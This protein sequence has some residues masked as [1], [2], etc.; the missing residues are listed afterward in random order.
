M[1]GKRRQEVKEDNVCK[2]SFRH[3]AA[4]AELVNSHDLL[5]EQPIIWDFFLFQACFEYSHVLKKVH[6]FVCVCESKREIEKVHVCKSA[7]MK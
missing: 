4:S 6:V 2:Q 1:N 3:N 7:L 5:L